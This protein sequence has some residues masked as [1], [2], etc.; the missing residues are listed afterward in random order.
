M[1]GSI[2]GGFG[3]KK[4]DNYLTLELRFLRKSNAVS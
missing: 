2:A 4:A 3:R 1:N